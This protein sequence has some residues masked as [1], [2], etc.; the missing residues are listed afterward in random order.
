[1]YG[2]FQTTFY[3]GYTAVGCFGL[4]LVCG[5]V[6]YLSASTFVRKIYGTVK[7]D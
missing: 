1:M 4:F 2:F 5:A 3:F 6:G 7:I